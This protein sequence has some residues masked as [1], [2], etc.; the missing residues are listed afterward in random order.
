MRWVKDKKLE[1]FITSLS[2]IEKA[3]EDKQQL[4]GT[5]LEV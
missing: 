3:I 1:I 5:D 2:E 4:S